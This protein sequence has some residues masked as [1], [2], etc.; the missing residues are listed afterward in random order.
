LFRKNA[1]TTRTKRALLAITVL[2]LTIG[3][4]RAQDELPAGAAGEGMPAT[5]SPAM[6]PA[7]SGAPIMNAAPYGM[8][9]DQFAPGPQ[10]GGFVDGGAGC[11]DGSCEADCHDPGYCRCLGHRCYSPSRGFR[12]PV[13]TP[14]Y[15]EAVVY[16]R[17]WPARWYGQPGWRLAPIYPMVYMPTDTTQLGFYYQR[18]PQ[19]LPNETMYPPAPR[20]SDWHR[21][22]VYGGVGDGMMAGGDCYGSAAAGGGVMYQGHPGQ[23][24]LPPGAMPNGAPPNAVPPNAVPPNAV[25]PQQQPVPP[26]APPEGQ[27][28]LYAPRQFRR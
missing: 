18:V 13:T 5:D 3:S 20:P 9:A 26:P 27:T 28:V 10:S 16:H 25:P 2:G 12:P 14:V 11:P 23:P 8:P 7:G 19:W 15:R 22:V 6:A 17:Y 1:M 24:G 21:R 4:A